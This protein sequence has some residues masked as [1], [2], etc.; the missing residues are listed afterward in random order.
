MHR[1]NKRLFVGGVLVGLSIVFPVQAALFD[2]SSEPGYCVGV[3][4]TV[5]FRFAGTRSEMGLFGTLEVVGDSVVAFPSGFRAESNDATQASIDANG[6]IQ[7]SVK[8]GYQF[9]SVSIVERGAY[10]MTA[11]DSRVD[12]TSF[13][14]VADWNDPI[15]GPYTSTDL[16]LKRALE[17]R[18]GTDTAWELRGTL[19]LSSA[20][21]DGVNEISLGLL[22]SLY[23]TG[24]SGTA[25]IEKLRSGAGLDVSI[26]TVPEVP[27]PAA[28]WLFGSGLVGLFGLTRRRRG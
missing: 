8:A 22:N 17:N 21:W 5:V 23:A 10:N 25:W 12:A 18:T 24:N 19:D 27:V 26:V 1:A 14:D 16:T 28:L 11:K 2:C 9:D 7:V 3:G 20:D 4:D 13:M 15:F 6:S